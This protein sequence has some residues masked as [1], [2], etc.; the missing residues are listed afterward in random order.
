MQC[1]P[2]MRWSPRL[3]GKLPVVID[4]AAESEKE[5][6]QDALQVLAASI[7]LPSAREQCGH[8]SSVARALI[9]ALA[10]C[11]QRGAMVILP[12]FEE[13]PPE[14][15]LKVFGV[16]DPESLMRRVLDGP[17]RTRPA[18]LKTFGS[19][20]VKCWPCIAAVSDE[21]LRD[22]CVEGL[23]LAFASLASTESEED[24][25]QAASAAVLDELLV[26]Y[27]N[28]SLPPLALVAFFHPA[29]HFKL[30]YATLLM[31][32]LR[33]LKAALPRLV[34]MTDLDCIWVPTRDQAIELNKAAG[35]PPRQGAESATDADK[36]ALGKEAASF[37]AALLWFFAYGGG[38]ARDPEQRHDST[39]L[40]DLGRGRKPTLPELPPPPDGLVQS[41]TECSRFSGSWGAS[42]ASA[43]A[44][45]VNVLILL[46]R[47]P[48]IAK[49]R[50]TFLAVAESLQ[51]GCQQPV[52]RLFLAESLC[53]VA[54]LWHLLEPAGAT[55]DS[56]RVCA[57]C[58][59]GLVLGSTLVQ[60]AAQAP[61]LLRLMAM[62]A[63]VLVL[64]GKPADLELFDAAL[65]RSGQDKLWLATASTAQVC[66]LLKDRPGTRD[67]VEA[68]VQRYLL[69]SLL[70][71]EAQARASAWLMISAAFATQATQTLL[72]VLNRPELLAKP[73]ALLLLSFVDVPNM[74]PAPRAKMAELLRQTELP[75]VEWA[76][77][78]DARGRLLESPG[79]GNPAVPTPV[80]AKGQSAEHFVR[81]LHLVADAQG[82]EDAFQAPRM[83]SVSGPP[84]FVYVQPL[85]SWVSGSSHVTLR[86]DL[87]NATALSLRDVTLTLSIARPTR[88]GERADKAP[89]WHFAEGLQRPFSNSP[90]EPITCRSS[91]TVWRDLYLRFPPKPVSLILSFS[92]AKV[93]PEGTLSGLTPA[94]TPMTRG[95]IEDIWSD[96]DDEE[97]ERL[98]FTCCPVS[99]PLSWYF[100][101]FYGFDVPGGA[102]PFPPPLI[103]AACPYSQ[104]Q[105]ALG[106]TRDWRMRGFHVFPKSGT[107]RNECQCFSGIACDS[108]SILCF[109]VRHSD[110]STLE[111][112]SNNEWLLQAATADLMFWMLADSEPPWPSLVCSQPVTEGSLTLREP[113][114]KSGQDT[115]IIEDARVTRQGAYSAWLK[116]TKSDN[117]RCKLIQSS[118][119]RYFTIDFDSQIMFYSHS[120]SQKKVS[121]P[122]PFKNILGAERLPLPEKK[123]RRNTMNFGFVLKTPQRNFELFT[124]SSAD[125]AQWTVSLNA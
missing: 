66:L 23:R 11:D 1:S 114:A 51:M 9:Q 115:L 88:M 56:R 31:E 94:S 98:R 83:I 50:N 97:D 107:A 69:A 28:V 25:L 93:V 68:L 111:V 89:P 5:L 76:E 123:S 54:S 33:D 58:V 35:L 14:D 57:V 10:K 49:A 20:L 104:M 19:C 81:W 72:P 86:I 43:R 55:S 29:W 59:E 42:F 99:A 117:A 82:P 90:L 65:R 106:I 75:G 78:R 118:N 125:A 30:I 108:E 67:L 46:C 8:F 52:L 26:A 102:S 63:K 22:A 85:I 37:R 79:R 110:E 80:A 16:L 7:L 40:V 21:A 15:L 121:Q 87:F 103:F 24:E 71:E 119:T 3:L 122:I 17:K 109:I 41:L 100:L 27:L 105:S 91:T 34:T 60:R 74:S 38:L 18:V 53:S 4:L 84:L 70:D 39:F 112:R 96:D 113:F 92:Y 61:L 47:G 2:S 64:H 95:G 44:R 13:L 12:A 62:A 124:N 32:V 77:V 36:E 6:R 120:T 45:L 48:D 73:E 101:P 116:K